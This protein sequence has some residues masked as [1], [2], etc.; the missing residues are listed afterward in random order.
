MDDTTENRETGGIEPQGAIANEAETSPEPGDSQSSYGETQ[1]ELPT[2]RGVS[3]RWRLWLTIATAL[4]ICAMIGLGLL[5]KFVLSWRGGRTWLGLGR[6]DWGQVHFWLAVVVLA[7]VVT[8]LA[9]HRAWIA[10]CWTRHVGSLR[11]PRTWVLL[12][13]GL[14]LMVL[15][16]VIPAGAAP[17]GRP[18]GRGHRAAAHQ[19]R[20]RVKSAAQGKKAKAN[21]PRRAR[22]T[23]H[24]QRPSPKR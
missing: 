18:G 23:K 1:D 16:L 12:G 14:L 9:V 11:S 17:P 3:G 15:P 22:P 6:Q 7:L 20:P 21:R 19:K 10:R 4:T 24:R 13:A 5:L 8:Q 2:A